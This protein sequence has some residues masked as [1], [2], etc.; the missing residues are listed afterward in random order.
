MLDKAM[1]VF[2]RHGYEG[3]SPGR[4]QAATGLTPPSIYNAFGSKEGLYE[5]CLDR[6]RAGPG[7]RAVGELTEPA[8]KDAVHAF[9]VAAAREFTQP[10]RLSPDLSSIEK[11]TAAHRT[12]TLSLIED[13][14][15][16]AGSAQPPHA[17]PLL[18]RDHP[19]HVGPGP[20]RRHG[21]GAGRRGGRGTQRVAAIGQTRIVHV[22]FV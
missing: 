17:G 19:G 4:L 1:T 15:R 5:A 10:G 7:A 9:L 16:R 12:R 6:Y 2:W 3:A 14:L 22:C 8:S 13:Y 20:R 21:G 18:R 11:A